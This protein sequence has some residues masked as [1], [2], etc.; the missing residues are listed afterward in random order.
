MSNRGPVHR[1]IAKRAYLPVCVI[2][3]AKGE[4]R[5]LTVHHID[6]DSRHNVL[7]NLCYACRRCHDLIHALEDCG[8]V[9]IAEFRQALAAQA[10]RYLSGNFVRAQKKKVA[11]RR[12][13]G[14]PKLGRVNAQ[15]PCAE[16]QRRK[17]LRE[18]REAR[19]RANREARRIEMIEKWLPLRLRRQEAMVALFSIP[20]TNH[21]M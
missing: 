10:R 9:E 5:S 15:T 13:S 16:V 2:C 6:H 12:K 14:K 17:K 21:A 1:S 11:K 3:F 20:R 19:K 8:Y 7:A 18:E 4:H